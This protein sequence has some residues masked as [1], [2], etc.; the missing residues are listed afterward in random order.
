MKT[1]ANSNAPKPTQTKQIVEY[2][3]DMPAKLNHDLFNLGKFRWG[4]MSVYDFRLLLMIAQQANKEQAEVVEHTKWIVDLDTV[5]EYLGFGEGGSSKHIATGEIVT[6]IEAFMGKTMRFFDPEQGDWDLWTW[7]SHVKV[8]EKTR[9]VSFQMTSAAAPLIAQVARYSMIKPANIAKLDTP[10][11]QILYSYFRDAVNRSRIIAIEVEMMQLKAYLG[12]EDSYNDKDGKR[13]FCRRVLGIEMPSKW[14]YNK[15]GANSY[16]Q[17]T[18]TAKGKEYGTLYGINTDSDITVNA[19]AYNRNKVV[20]LHFDINEKKRVYATT[21]APAVAE[22]PKIED[23]FVL[24]DRLC[25]GDT[26]GKIDLPAAVMFDTTGQ[27][28]WW[29]W[30]LTMRQ[31]LAEELQKILQQVFESVPEGTSFDEIN[32]HVRDLIT[33]YKAAHQGEEPAVPWTQWRAISEMHRMDGKNIPGYSIGAI[34]KA[35]RS[36]EGEEKWTLLWNALRELPNRGNI[37][38]ASSWIASCIKPK[39]C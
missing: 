11:K 5:V 22:E 37:K 34:I 3:G 1:K 28:W 24:W 8:S 2:N 35:V 32:G 38:D 19:Y 30:H 33:R 23:V 27:R 25:L 26:F 7:C 39:K 18:K 16:W 10:Y 14:K 4:N 13:D 31:D 36:T 9:K 17:Y 21:V 29:Q 20:Y 15:T 6:Y 12:L